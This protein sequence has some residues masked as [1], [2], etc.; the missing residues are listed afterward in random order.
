MTPFDHILKLYEDHPTV[1]FEADLEA[2]FQRGYLVSTPEAFA[3]VR[4]VRKDWTPESL[5]NPF[6]VEPL[7]TADCWFIWA[8]A[9]DFKV[10]ARWL[11]CLLPWIG[12]ARRGKPPVFRETSRL[13]FGR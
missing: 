4:P 10:A 12:Y 2:H 6:H 9:G 1:N 13:T 5:R 7:A 11:P 3:M 8:L